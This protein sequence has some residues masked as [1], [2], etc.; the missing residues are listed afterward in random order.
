[1]RFSL[2]SWQHY[3]NKLRHRFADKMH[4]LNKNNA[5]HETYNYRNRLTN[6]IR[7]PFVSFAY[8]F[9]TVFLPLPC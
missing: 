2:D 5:E 1:M 6:H 3:V 8:I 7:A 9:I 4:I